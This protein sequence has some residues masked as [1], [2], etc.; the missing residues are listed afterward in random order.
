MYYNRIEILRKISWK[1]GEK[2]N[3]NH[4]FK[5]NNFTPLCH[6]QILGT[7]N[8]C[9]L[10]GGIECIQPNSCH[11]F[12][13]AGNLRSLEASRDRAVGTREWG[14]EAN[15]PQ[16]LTNLEAKHFPS[17]DLEYW[18]P[19]QIFGP[20]SGTVTRS[21]R[22]GRLKTLDLILKNKKCFRHIHRPA[23]SENST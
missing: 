13:N 21:Q 2:K 7:S 1:V 4:I 18:L 20:S 14:G 3:Y 11:D 17:A 8:I 16:I 23:N 10:Q 22:S 12:W 15:P 19:L 6:S 5:R 9:V